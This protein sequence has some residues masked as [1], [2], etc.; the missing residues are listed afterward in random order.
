MRASQRSRAAGYDEWIASKRAKADI[1]V[2]Q[3]TAQV[4]PKSGSAANK[5]PRPSLSRRANAI[6]IRQTRSSASKS[7]S[8]VTRGLI[9]L[10]S[11]HQPATHNGRDKEEER[12]Q[13]SPETL[14]VQALQDY[15]FDGDTESPTNIDE[16]ASV[17]AQ[18][19]KAIS[20]A[21]AGTFIDADPKAFSD[22]FASANVCRWE[23]NVPGLPSSADQ[24]GSKEVPTRFMHECT[25]SLGTWFA[26]R[27]R[28][29]IV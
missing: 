17:F 15:I 27:P 20:C 8:S 25:V 12:Q 29:V 9:S 6:L 2:P 24:T 21:V 13:Y 26:A 4:K 1:Q 5:E 23:Y 16:I 28:P 22:F 11:G 18:D 14:K 19:I 3:H 10:P 7:D